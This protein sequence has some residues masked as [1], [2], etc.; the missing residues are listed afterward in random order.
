[1]IIKIAIAEDNDFLAKSLIEKLSLFP[2]RF[3]M[4][5]RAKKWFR[6]G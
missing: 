4:K 2:D 3:S 1:M 6:D 5:F